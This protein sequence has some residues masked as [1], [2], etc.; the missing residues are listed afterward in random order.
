MRR[1]DAARFAQLQTLAE[2]R[3]FMLREWEWEE[4]VYLLHI[5]N[6]RRKVCRRV[7]RAR[8]AAPTADYVEKALGLNVVQ[9]KGP[10]A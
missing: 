8:T 6:S 7:G 5:R 9:F 10:D 2:K 3:G 4:G 1:F